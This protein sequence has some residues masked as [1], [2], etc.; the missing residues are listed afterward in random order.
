MT[1]AGRHTEINPRAPEPQ[2]VSQDHTTSYANQYKSLVTNKNKKERKNITT[3]YLLKL[4]SFQFPITSKCV[5]HG[6]GSRR[7]K[8]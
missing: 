6:P 1:T 3:L 8:S 4:C 5:C 7:T 2:V